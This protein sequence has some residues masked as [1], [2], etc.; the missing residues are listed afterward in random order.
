VLLEVGTANKAMQSVWDNLPKGKNSVQ[1]VDNVSVDAS[2]L[3]PANHGYYT[4]TGSLTTPPCSEGVTWFVLKT[5][6]TISTSELEVFSKR[7]P[8]NARPVQPL[9][10]RVVKE[11]E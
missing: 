9:H 3:L 7:Y 4:F 2:D 6:T 10:G 11:S 1:V 8:L 5:P